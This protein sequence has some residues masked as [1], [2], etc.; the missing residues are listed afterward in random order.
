MGATS[1]DPIEWMSDLIRLEISLWDQID[2]RLREDHNLPLAMF[3]PLY[4]VGRDP[5]RTL[6]VGELAE[7]LRLTVGGTSKIVDRGEQAGLFQ[8]EPDARDRRVSR[9]GLTEAGRRKLAVA[10]ETCEVSLNAVLDAAL[11]ADQQQ[12]MHG[13]ISRVLDANDRGRDA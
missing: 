7:K 4:V 12:E 5:E 1:V 13:L 2:A 10:S 3:W 8:R 9:V 11:D 6:R